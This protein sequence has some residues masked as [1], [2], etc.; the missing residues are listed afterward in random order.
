MSFEGVGSVAL[1]PAF[2]GVQCWDL[3]SFDVEWQ[4]FLTAEQFQGRTKNENSVFKR[5]TKKIF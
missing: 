1:P 4:V 3:R 2:V 5:L